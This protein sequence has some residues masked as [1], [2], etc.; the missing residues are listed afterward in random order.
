[1]EIAVD[2]RLRELYIY[3]T[4]Q[5]SIYIIYIYAGVEHTDSESAHFFT[6]KKLAQMFRL[7]LLTQ[8]GVRTA[9]LWTLNPTLFQ[10][11]HP[12]HP[13]TS[14]CI[15]YSRVEQI[16]QNERV[17]FAQP[18]YFKAKSHYNTILLSLLLSAAHR[19][20]VLL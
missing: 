19:C 9:D 13:P 8:A 4:G 18:L 15:R 2:A 12:R 10:L 17:W 6:R 3:V 1:M 7:V 16:Y 20:A 14:S 5:T 11:S